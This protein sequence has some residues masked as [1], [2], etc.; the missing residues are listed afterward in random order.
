MRRYFKASPHVYEAV[1]SQLDT[2]WGHPDGVTETAF[3][4]VTLAPKD[5][6]GKALLAVWASF[7]EMADVAAIL[8]QLIASGAV[9]EVTEE[10]F[11]ACLQPSQFP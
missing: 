5:A 1:R 9:T 4:P 10:E 2:L 11:N 3:Q 7:C 6:D 8:P